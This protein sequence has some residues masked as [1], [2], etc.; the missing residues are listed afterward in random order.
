MHV[1]KYSCHTFALLL[2]CGCRNKNEYTR[3]EERGYHTQNH[4]TV[5]SFSIES[6]ERT[7]RPLSF[8]EVTKFRTKLSG[9]TS[10][11]CTSGTEEK[12]CKLWKEFRQ[13]IPEEIVQEL[14]KED[15]T[16][17]LENY[18]DRL[19]NLFKAPT[20]ENEK[21]VID[22]IQKL[23][24]N[25]KLTQAWESYLAARYNNPAT[26]YLTKATLAYQ[27]LF[28]FILEENNTLHIK[29]KKCQSNLVKWQKDGHPIG[30]ALWKLIQ[31]D[32]SR[33]LNSSKSHK[34]NKAAIA[35]SLK[36]MDQL[37]DNP[38]SLSYKDFLETLPYGIG[39]LKDTLY[40]VGLKESDHINIKLLRTY[41]D[42]TPSLC[43]YA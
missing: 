26:I 32:Y 17:L 2:F 8:D 11:W 42:L 1:K 13:T 34:Y 36:L 22:A 25:V 20:E 29:L 19:G 23:Q 27:E 40:E 24:A 43:L 6:F 39:K 21:E 9:R 3:Q 33:Q 4:H 31:Q 37:A 12:P 7:I 10:E 38:Y 16:T 30:Q 41:I 15:D 14:K 35:Q 5:V 18:Y 28:Y